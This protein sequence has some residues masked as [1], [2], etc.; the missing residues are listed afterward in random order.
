MATGGTPKNPEVD[1]AGVRLHEGVI[2]SAL[3]VARSLSDAR[4]M[5]LRYITV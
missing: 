1:A 2:P 4:K 3:R 5:D